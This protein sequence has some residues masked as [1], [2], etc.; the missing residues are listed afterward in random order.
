MPLGELRVKSLDFIVH[1]DASRL[2]I[3]VKGRRYPARA[4]GKPRHVWE[5]WST[6]EDVSGLERWTALFG[7]GYRG[8]LV[9]TYQLLPTVELPDDTDDLWT[10]QGRRYL[11]RA[12]DVAEY[13]K[14]M[15][16]RSP[17]WG[18]VTLPGEVFR[19]LVRPLRHFTH[20]EPPVVEDCPF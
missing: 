13:R 16:V 5:C 19:R 17:R 10:W 11:F 12:V 1:G 14:H 2:L 7:P 8:L 15:R 4:N 20:V 9:F 3:D 6:A 18:T